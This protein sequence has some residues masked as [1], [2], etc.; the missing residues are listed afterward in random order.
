MPV[1]AA[2]LHQRLN[3]QRI[4]HFT[5]RYGVRAHARCYVFVYISKIFKCFELKALEELRSLEIMT[6]EEKS[7]ES[8]VSLFYIERGTL[9]A[10]VCS[11]ALPLA[12]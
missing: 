1:E 8:A 3:H 9:Q 6:A 4:N 7:E 2:T 11:G 5:K 10:W 12:Q